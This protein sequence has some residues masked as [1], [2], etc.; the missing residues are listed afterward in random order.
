MEYHYRVET[1]A[2]PVYEGIAGAGLPALS[3]ADRRIISVEHMHNRGD[4]W[5]ITAVT[6]QQVIREAEPA[7]TG[8]MWQE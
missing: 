6:E 7:L 1:F 8:D 5:L 2:V 3:L 4:T